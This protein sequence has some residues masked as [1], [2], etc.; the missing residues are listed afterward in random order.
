MLQWSDG[1]C[2][3]DETLGRGKGHDREQSAMYDG[4]AAAMAPQRGEECSELE[5]GAQLGLDRVMGGR[6]RSLSRDGSRAVGHDSLRAVSDVST[7]ASDATRA[8]AEEGI[9][10]RCGGMPN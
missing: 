6:M 4:G 8:V 3:G 2:R 10:L 7:G 9:K 5:A 1:C